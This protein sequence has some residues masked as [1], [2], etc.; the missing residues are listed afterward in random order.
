MA[1]VLSI[2]AAPGFRLLRAGVPAGAGGDLVDLEIADGVI[3]AVSPHRPEAAGA[4]SVDLAG[5]MVL[6]CPVDLHTHLDKG[7][8]W[9]RAANPDGTFMGALA[10]AEADRLSRWSAEDVALRMEF[11]LRCAYAHGTRAIRT[12]L[13]SQPPQHAI[14]WPILAELRDRWAGRIGLAGRGLVPTRALSR[15]GG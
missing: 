1:G 7:H 9:P 8:I 10:A 2:P 6:P 3:A 13:D 14:T 12:H 11:G 4:P 15:P 5:R